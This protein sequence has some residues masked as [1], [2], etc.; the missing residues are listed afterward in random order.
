MAGLGGASVLV[1]DTTQAQIHYLFDAAGLPRWLFAQDLQNPDPL[2]P[3]VPILQFSGYCAV[4][5]ETTV[6]SVQ[7]GTLGLGFD[8]DTAGFWSLDYDFAAPVNGSVERT[9]QV[10]KLTDTLG[11]P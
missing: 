9:D 1:N 7:V 8:S 6:D 2:A 4:C 5:D 11:C 3:S 10:I